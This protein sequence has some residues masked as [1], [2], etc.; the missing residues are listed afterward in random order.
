MRSQRCLSF[1]RAK[2]VDDAVD[3]LGPL[4]RARVSPVLDQKRVVAVGVLFGDHFE[5]DVVRF[6]CGGV[7]WNKT[8]ATT[9]TMDMCVDRD[10]GHSETKAQDDA[11][12]LWTDA[13]ERGEPISRLQHRHACKIVD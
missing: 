13:R 3:A 9:D 7:V 12:G 6:I 4:C 1:P 2:V 8:K 11:G 10:R 5:E